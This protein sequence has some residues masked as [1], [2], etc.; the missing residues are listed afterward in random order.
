MSPTHFCQRCAIAYYS[1]HICDHCGMDTAPILQAQPVK[2][3]ETR[4]G[5]LPECRNTTPVNTDCA[6]QQVRVLCG[7]AR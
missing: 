6:M 4:P 2:P 7:G 3:I 5:I 1:A